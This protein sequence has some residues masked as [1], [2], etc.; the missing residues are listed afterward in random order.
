M[1]FTSPRNVFGL[2]RRYL[3]DIPPSHD[4]EENV[5]INDLCSFP[6]QDSLP[7]KYVLGPYPNTSSFLLG[8]WYWNGGVQKSQE[9]FKKL[10][11]IVGSD[12]FRPADISNV[13]WKQVNNALTETSSAF[14]WQDESGWISTP[15]AISVPFHRGTKKPGA[16]DYIVTNF[17]HRALVSV[18]R[19]RLEDH[20]HAQRFHY[21]PYELLWKR[22]TEQEV[23][24][25]GELYTSQVF[26]DAQRNLD[27]SPGEPD[28]DLPRAIVGLMFWSDA[29]HLTSFSS[30]QLWPLYLFFGNES[31]YRRCKPSCNL[32]SHVA[33]FEKVISV[34][35]SHRSS[36]NSTSFLASRRIQRSRNCY[37]GEMSKRCSVNALSQRITARAMEDITRRGVHAGI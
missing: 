28:C 27:A 21:Q 14:E 32:C 10:V 25:H 24:V 35:H 37:Q 3:T 12:D 29:T 7:T 23:R 1:V 2:S 20:D 36:L 31:K 18:I 11:E 33:Y 8:E 34:P 17:H 16:Q 5:T 13:N 22:G 19:E 26:L 15:V 6:T 9:S 30:A 4:P